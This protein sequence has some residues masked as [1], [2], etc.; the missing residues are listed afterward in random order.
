M[1]LY[2]HISFPSLLLYLNTGPH[3]PLQ[4][5]L[6]QLPN[7]LCFQCALLYSVFH[8]A[9]WAIF[10]VSK[11]E[12]AIPKFS[13]DGETKQKHHHQQQNLQTNFKA[14]N[15]QLNS[16]A[17]HIRY[18]MIWSLSTWVKPSH[19]VPP[20]ASY[21]QPFR[22]KNGTGHSL[23]TSAL[24]MLL[25]FCAPIVL[26]SCPP[27]KNFLDVPEET[28]LLLPQ[29]M[30]TLWLHYN[31]YDLALKWF[32]VYMSYLCI[33]GFSWPGFLSVHLKKQYSRVVRSVGSEVRLPGFESALFLFRQLHGF[34][35]P[36][37]S[38]L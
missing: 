15:L 32:I 7:S 34:S 36:Q 23:N 5:F 27:N 1:F 8:T 14:L 31:I 35:M 26:L 28:W 11:S 4:S 22:T 12:H 33:E 17:C 24:L 16:W 6:Q 38:H 9:A 29:P 3:H 37:I 10:L 30:Y 20:C 25:G 13:T 21:T 19:C 18:S 2:I